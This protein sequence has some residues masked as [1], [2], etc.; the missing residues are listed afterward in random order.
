M[1]DKHEIAVYDIQKNALV[2]F[3][4]GPRST[5]FDLKFNQQED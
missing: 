5:I 2:A 1:S 3:G 4:A